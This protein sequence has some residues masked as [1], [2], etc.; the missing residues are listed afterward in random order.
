MAP[1]V[2]TGVFLLQKFEMGLQLSDC[3]RRQVV[4][5]AEV[6]DKARQSVAEIGSDKQLRGLKAKCPGHAIERLRIGV[7]IEATLQP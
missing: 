4:T 2:P 7:L 6:G 1:S 5:A 3:L